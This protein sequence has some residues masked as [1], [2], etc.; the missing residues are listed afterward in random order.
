MGVTMKPFSRRLRYLVHAL[1]MIVD[2]R[3]ALASS[4]I[5]FV[6]HTANKL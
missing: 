6:R 1:W 2:S 5:D 4:E 3:K